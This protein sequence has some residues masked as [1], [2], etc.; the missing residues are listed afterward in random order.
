ML[1]LSDESI[2]CCSSEQM[3]AQYNNINGTVLYKKQLEYWAGGLSEIKIG[4]QQCMALSF[5]IPGTGKE[6]CIF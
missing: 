6:R 3:L 2:V 4:N 1:V 5:E